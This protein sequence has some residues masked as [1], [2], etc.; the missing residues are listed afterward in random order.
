MELKVWILFQSVLSLVILMSKNRLYEVAKQYGV[1]AKTARDYLISNGY[2]LKNN[3][4]ILSEDELRLLEEFCSRDKEES[5]NTVAE[6]REGS[7]INPVILL[8]EWDEDAF[9]VAEIDASIKLNS[10][11]LREICSNDAEYYESYDMAVTAAQEMKAQRKKA[12]SIRI[13]E[14]KRTSVPSCSVPL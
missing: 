7:D 6:S 11:L 3:M 12:D 14:I 13:L 5:S 9:Y 1:P 2:S 4:A 8:V 10:V